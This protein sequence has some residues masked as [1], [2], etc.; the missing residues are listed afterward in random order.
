MLLHFSKYTHRNA[1]KKKGAT[2]AGGNKL[3][4]Q[5][6]EDLRR[7][8]LERELENLQNL[9][10]IRA[11]KIAGK[12]AIDHEKTTEGMSVCGCMCV[13]VCMCRCVYVCVLACTHVRACVRG[14]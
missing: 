11:A 14:I 3:T 8:T 6:L 7:W 5:N 1:T 12:S 2:S 9:K 10:P 4:P 13:Y